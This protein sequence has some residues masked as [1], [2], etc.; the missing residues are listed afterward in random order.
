MLNSRATV[1]VVVVVA[2]TPEARGRYDR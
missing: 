2:M 1:L